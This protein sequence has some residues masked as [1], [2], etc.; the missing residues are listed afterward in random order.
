MTYIVS[1][2]TLNL[3]SINLGLDVSLMTIFLALKVMS[4]TLALK[5]EEGLGLAT[6][7]LALW[8]VAFALYYVITCCNNVIKT[9][10]WWKTATPMFKAHLEL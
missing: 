2:G 3:N 5:A 8:N 4:S 7:S 10:A 9:V 6:K 1:S